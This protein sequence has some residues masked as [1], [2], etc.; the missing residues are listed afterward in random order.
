MLAP[1]LPSPIIPS[2]ITKFL[3]FGWLLSLLGAGLFKDPHELAV[4]TGNLGDGRFARGLF[5]PPADE[6][7]PEDGAPDG[8][9]DEAGHLGRGCQPFMNLLVVFAPAQDNAAD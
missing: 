8:K 7:F 9:A 1:I 4:A 2:C 3:S 6:R 5:I